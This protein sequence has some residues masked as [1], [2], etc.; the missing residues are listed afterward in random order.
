MYNYLFTASKGEIKGLVA[1]LNT[2]FVVK[3]TTIVIHFRNVY[4]LFKT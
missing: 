1:L 3:T 4:H 2:S